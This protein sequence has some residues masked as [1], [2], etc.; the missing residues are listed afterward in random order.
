MNGANACVPGGVLRPQ[1]RHPNVRALVCPFDKKSFKLGKFSYSAQPFFWTQYK[2]RR[3]PGVGLCCAWRDDRDA[4]P[5]VH[6]F[7]GSRV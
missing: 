2:K 6:G 5:G 3:G 4:S 1:G 7:E